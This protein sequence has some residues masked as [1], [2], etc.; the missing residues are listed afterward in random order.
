MSGA[1][2]PENRLEKIRATAKRTGSPDMLRKL[3][4]V[5]GAAFRIAN[6]GSRQDEEE[7]YIAGMADAWQSDI[8]RAQRQVGAL[9][10][11]SELYTE[12]TSLGD[13][14]QLRAAIVALAGDILGKDGVHAALQSQD[15]KASKDPFQERPCP[16][17]HA[18]GWCK[19]MGDTDAWD[20]L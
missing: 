7:A 6:F 11:L 9:L 20:H 15:E 13:V 14:M 19:H 4:G 18:D 2:T 16:L 10:R 5:G 3:L 17:C 12:S 8:A 1:N